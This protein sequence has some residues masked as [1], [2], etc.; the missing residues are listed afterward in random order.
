[1]NT[2]ERKT[3]VGFRKMVAQEFVSTFRIES[4]RIWMNEFQCYV[5][6]W[7]LLVSTPIKKFQNSHCDIPTMYLVDFEK[8]FPFEIN[9]MN[10]NFERAY[11]WIDCFSSSTT[12]ISSF[13][14][15]LPFKV[16]VLFL[17]EEIN[18]EKFVPKPFSTW[19]KP[20]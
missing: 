15:I 16:V 8:S 7:P 4:N 19:P 20:N 17:Y 18:F 3:E 9:S 2:T 6:E 5:Y 1:M 10:T 14:L 12:T 11:E 13:T